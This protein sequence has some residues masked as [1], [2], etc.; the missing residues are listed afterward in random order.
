MHMNQHWQQVVRL[1]FS[2]L[3]A[4]VLSSVQ[5]WSGLCWHLVTTDH[6]CPEHGGGAP[7]PG[8]A[9]AGPSS[10]WAWHSP[11]STPSYPGRRRRSPGPAPTPRGSTGRSSAAATI[12][13]LRETQTFNTFFTETEITFYCHCVEYSES[14][15]NGNTNAK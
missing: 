1:S 4:A 2:P 14:W 11:S 12:P 13:R 6:R 5:Q 15:N 3:E 8:P 10:S 7:R 9:A